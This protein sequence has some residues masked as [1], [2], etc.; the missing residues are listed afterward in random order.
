[1]FLADKITALGGQLD[2]NPSMPTKV[3]TA[4]EMMAIDIAAERQIIKNYA[5]RIAQA[6]ELGETG[7]V[8]RLEDILAE[9]T[10]HAEQLERLGR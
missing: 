3:R 2:I 9:E 6:E 10:D 1:M 5:T 4:K 8:I 7:L